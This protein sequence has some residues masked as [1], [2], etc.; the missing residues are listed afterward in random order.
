[1]YTDEG[2]RKEIMEIPDKFIGSWLVNIYQKAT[3]PDFSFWYGKEGIM[4]KIIEEERK[5]AWRS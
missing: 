1:M 5:R 2:V 4:E 3:R